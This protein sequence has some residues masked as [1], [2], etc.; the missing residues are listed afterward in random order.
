MKYCLSLTKATLILLVLVSFCVFPS[1]AQVL[2]KG[3]DAVL[4]TYSDTPAGRPVAYVKRIGDPVGAGAPFDV[5]GTNWAAGSTTIPITNWTVTTMGQVFGAAIDDIGSV[6]F[7][8]TRI[9]YPGANAYDC[10]SYATLPPGTI[11]P[12]GFH[13]VGG[14]FG[15]IY[16]ASATALNTVNPLVTANAT[17]AGAGVGTTKLYNTGYGIGNLAHSTVYNKIY[18]SNLEDGKIYCIDRVTGNVDFEFDPLVADNG[19]AGLAPYGERVIA[20]AVNNEFDGTTR[21]Y[22]SVLMSKAV[23]GCQSVIRSVQLTA[24]G[25]FLPATDVL[26]IN[27]PLSDGQT[28]VPD[29]DFSVRGEM[30]VGEKGNAHNA[31]V[32]QY[33]GHHNAWSIPQFVPS[34][35]YNLTMM[36]SNGGVDYGY[37]KTAN[38]FVCDSLTW[39]TENAMDNVK[40]YG[41]HSMP[42]NGFLPFVGSGFGPQTYMVDLDNIPG[43]MPFYQK[44]RFGDVEVYDTTCGQ[45]PTDICGLVSLTAIK[46][47]GPGCCYNLYVSNK[48]HDGYFTGIEI[49]TG[50]LN[51]DNVSAGSTWGGITY[52]T[53]QKVGF[54]DPNHLMY[55][56]KDGVGGPF[57]L[58]T[59]CVSGT[60]PD[61]LKVKWI[62]NAPQFDTV[63]KKEVAIDGCGVPVD[64][65]CVG[66]FNQ[67]A[68]C[69]NGVVKMQ[70]Q[71]KNNST[72]TM[73]SVT[74]FG[75]NPNVKPVSSFFPIADVPPG[76]TSPL[77][78]VNLIVK[79]GDTTGC[80]FFSAC[81]INVYPGT[82]GIYPKFCCMDS[83]KYCIA[84]PKCD[85]CDAINITAEKTDPN[86]ASCCYKLTLTN[87]LLGSTITCLRFKGLGGAQFAVFS[88]WNIQAPVSSSKITIC[89]PGSGL[90]TGTYP[91]FANF[92]ITGTSTP[93]H[94]VSVD[95]LDKNGNIIC[96]KLIEFGHCEL[97]KPTCANIVE[98]SL[99]CDGTK[100]FYSFHIKNNSTFPLYQVDLRL[101]DSTFKLDKYVIIPDT[102]IVPGVTGG[103][104]LVAIDSP[105]SGNKTFCMYLTGH[106]NI[107][108]PDS[109][110]ATLCCT[111]S[112]GVICLPFP[113][114][115]SACCT[116]CCEFANMVIP[117]GITPNNDG[118]NDMFVIQN[119]AVC[120][121]IKITVFNRWGNV[122]YREEGYKNTWTGLNSK[123]EQL[124]QGTYFVVIELANGSKKGTYIDIRY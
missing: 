22:Y 94:Q 55:L 24:G 59:I 87:N 60:G 77:Y 73:R 32:Y 29:I 43:N 85:S 112:L 90:G 52:Q 20:V 13:A 36:N 9:Y 41:I 109:L 70:F 65:N 58:A 35:N 1:S 71:L 47:P 106:N 53:A 110:S 82:S 10:L 86:S 49:E 93:P 120:S 4:T 69:E 76:G 26:E 72:F 123:G 15:L 88:G 92:C 118:F 116:D 67:K 84:I 66:I 80:F 16:K 91:E 98:D 34:G 102:P 103:P 114:C 5:A 107:Y 18:A 117:T 37:F 83:I 28:Y 31:A 21:V 14:S 3:M 30:L 19:T 111:D 6:Y 95:F 121:T 64:T 50:H 100:A 51:I 99:Y 7:G 33:Y 42:H 25:N 75:L 54:G 48:Y 57:L 62:G 44:G 17:I 40:W 8:A 113:N 78:T 104:Y 61:V 108:I 2:Q 23:A 74:I 115:D 97:V 89:A 38:G 68:I 11:S 56:P 12:N 81:D 79:N 45:G 105:T 96:T 119:S 46:D 63:C 39:V 27:L 124:P 122:V 101:A